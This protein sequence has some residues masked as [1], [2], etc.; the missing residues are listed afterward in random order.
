M[1]KEKTLPEATLCFLVRGKRVR[2]ALKTQDVGKDCWNGYGGGIEK[3]EKPKEAAVREI[4]EEAWV[5]VNPKH[6]KKVAII[7]FHNTRSDGSTFVCRVYV[8]IARK[9]RGKPKETETMVKPTMFGMNNLPFEKMMPADR[10]WLPIVLKGRMI[11]A[12][13][14]YGPFQKKLLSGVEIHE[15]ISLP[16]D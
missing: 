2:L 15:V 12:V 8:Y 13:A 7:D 3:G 16:D 9:W 1:E 10:V 6:L 5:K 14:R 11:I 4:W